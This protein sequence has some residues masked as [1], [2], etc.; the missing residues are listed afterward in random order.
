MPA[1]SYIALDGSGKQVNGSLS[2]STRAEA[3]RKLEAQRLTPVK[4]TEDAQKTEAKA[5]AKTEAELPA[6]LLKRAQ[7]I[8][9]TEE[10]AD[11][12]DGG[13]QL[14]QALRVM[15]ERQESPIIRRVSKLIRDQVREGATFS[16]ALANAS[17]SFDDLY[18][19]LASA[20]EVSGSLPQI[21]RRLTASITQIH[22]LQSRV[23]QAMIYP[24]FMIGALVVLMVVLSTV[25]IPQLTNLLAKT[26]QKLPLAMQVLVMISDGVKH[27][28]WLIAALITI[29]IIMFRSYIATDKGRF[30]WHHATLD[31][32]LFGP[33][34]SSR[35]YAQFCGSLGNLVNNG[36]PLLNGLKLSVRA[37]SNIFL[38]DLLNKVVAMVGEGGA[39][40][41]SMRKVAR[42]PT[43]LV[44]MISVG[45]QTG[46]LGRSLEKAA[47]RYDKELDKKIKRMTAMITPVVIIIMAVVVGGVAY[48]V[49]TSIFQSMSGLKGR[50]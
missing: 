49:V 40:S 22:E 36:V 20:G 50:G 23:V 37:T 10:L 42:F 3:Y 17:P 28:W 4:V 12:L 19:N 31:M 35:F 16:K 39:L 25:L 45:E 11:L 14:E 15:E 46:H 43:L 32:P 6:P 5:A 1:F 38:K 30:W 24:A 18:C 27:W 44:D 29:A 21:L 26:G 9:F 13:L 47:Q 48:S 33:V 8:H 2:V 34:I 7:L 41:N